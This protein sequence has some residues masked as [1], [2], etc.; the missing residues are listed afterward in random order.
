MAEKQRRTCPSN[1]ELAGH[2]GENEANSN[3]YKPL[4]AG[5]IGDIGFIFEE[6]VRE[7]RNAQTPN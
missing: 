3:F 2:S 1:F 7:N 5:K 4:M 6:V